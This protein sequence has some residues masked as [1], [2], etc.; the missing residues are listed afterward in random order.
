MPQT[1]C[2]KKGSVSHVRRNINLSINSQSLGYLFMQKMRIVVLLW[3][4]CE[5]AVF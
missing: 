1:L 4:L 5:M 2:P 3:K